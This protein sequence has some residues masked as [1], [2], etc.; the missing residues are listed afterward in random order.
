MLNKVRNVIV[1]NFMGKLCVFIHYNFV[2][3]L[4]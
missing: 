2:I 3:Y 4:V 1:R